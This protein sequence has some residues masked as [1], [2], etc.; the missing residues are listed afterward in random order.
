MPKLTQKMVDTRIAPATGKELIRDEELRGFGLSVTSRSKTYF[1]ECRV[2]GKQR[3]ATIGRA[4]LL[5]LEEARLKGRRLLAEMASGFDPHAE[6][7]NKRVAS[8]TLLELLEEYLAVRILK[9]STKEVYRREEISPR[10]AE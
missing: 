10:V 2:K 6:K 5:S 8:I 9:E 7:R 3:R 1:V 4:D